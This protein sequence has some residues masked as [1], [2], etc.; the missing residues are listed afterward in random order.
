M[1]AW[2]EGFMADKLQCGGKRERSQLMRGGEVG[3]P[4]ALRHWKISQQ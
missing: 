1:Q 3:P 4:L 2:S